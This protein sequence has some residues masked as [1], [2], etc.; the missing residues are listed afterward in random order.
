MILFLS[1][2][3]GEDTIATGIIRAMRQARADLPVQ[4]MPLVGEGLAYRRAGIDVVGPARLLPSGGLIH[5]GVSNLVSDMK[6]GLAAMTWQQIRTLWGLRGQVRQVVAVGDVFPVVLG[7]LFCR[8]PIL[9]VGTARS[10]WFV[11][12]SKLETWLFCWLCRHV[13]ARDEPTARTLASA[14]V[15]ASWVGNAMMDCLDGTGQALPLPTDRVPV[16][17]LPGSREATYRDLPVLLAAA[18]EM[19]AGY[20]FVANLA[21]STDVAVL[22]QAAEGWAWHAAHGWLG[23]LAADG[24]EL[25][26]AKGALG[27][28]LDACRLVLGQA[29]TANEQAAGLGRPVVA[30]DSDKPGKYGLGWYRARQKGL[31]GDALRVVGRDGPALAQAAVEILESPDLY[32][33]MERTGRERLGPPGASA[34]MAAQILDLL[35]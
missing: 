22:R 15:P 30:F 11:P 4:A 16:A 1:N 34:Q 7:G 13:W 2:G 26:L 20:V 10:D 24:V 14:G 12:Y 25:Y 19:G 17:V 9:F 3:Y 27:S 28:V 31:L 6:A 5:S 8:R 33:H 21:E 35:P 29:G 32:A 18:R 23:M